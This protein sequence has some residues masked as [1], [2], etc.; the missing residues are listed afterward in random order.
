MSTG[1]NGGSAIQYFE[2]SDGLEKRDNTQGLL[3]LYI[4]VYRQLQNEVAKLSLL[5]FDTRPA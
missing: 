4:D 5:Y 1:L 3:H 2:H